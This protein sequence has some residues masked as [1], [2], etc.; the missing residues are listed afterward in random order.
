[1]SYFILKFN[2]NLHQLLIIS[3]LGTKQWYKYKSESTNLLNRTHNAD[4]KCSTFCWHV[5]YKC[6]PTHLDSETT[7]K[8]PALPT[9][10]EIT[11]TEHTHNLH[12]R[13][14][15]THIMNTRTG[16]RQHKYT[17]TRTQTQLHIRSHNELRPGGLP[18]RAYVW[19]AG[20][21]DGTSASQRENTQLTRQPTPTYVSIASCRAR[22]KR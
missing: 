3:T 9:K 21:W 6:Q 19:W 20:S 1:M 2:T 16:Y 8:G 13:L 15:V 18:K 10:L 22:C 7:A 4:S 5:K 17:T 11:W 14:T 12:V